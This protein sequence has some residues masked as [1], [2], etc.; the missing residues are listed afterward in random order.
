MITFM[1]ITLIIHNLE[2]S[3]ESDPRKRKQSVIEKPKEQFQKYLG[4]Q[5][6]I[7]MLLQLAKVWKC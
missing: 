5:V 7:L 4:V 6:I 1:T 2:R 3:Q